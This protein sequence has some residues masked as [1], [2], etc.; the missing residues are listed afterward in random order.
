MHLAK[1]FPESDTPKS[2]V[3][4]SKLDSNSML[5]FEISQDEKPTPKPTVDSDKLV[6]GKTKDILMMKKMFEKSEERPT[7]PAVYNWR[8]Y[9]TAMM[10]SAAAIIIGYDG[11]FIGGTVALDSFLAEFGL[12]KMST[13]HADSIVSDIISVFHAGC[14]FGA[15][16]SYPF[17]YYLG[18]RISLIVAAATITIGSAIMLAASSK[19]GLAPLYVGRV[20]A[21]LAVGFSTNL[22]PVYLSEIS[23]PA[24]RGRVIALYEIGWRIGDLVGFWINYG[25]DSHIASS[26]KQW[27]IPFAIQLIPS[28]LFLAGSVI[29]KESPRW[30]FSVNRH[31]Q[32]I[33]NLTW[34]RN[35]NE[36]DEYIVYEVNQVKE[37]IE[38][39][40]NNVGD[41]LFDPFK[42]VF[43]SKDRKILYRLCLT[44]CLFLF[45]NFLGIQSINYYSPK[46]FKSLGVKG[47][48][49][50]LFSTGIFGIVKFVCTFIYILFIV[51]TFGR[52]KAFMCSS[53]I[54][55]I[56]FWYIGSYLKIN[57]P[58][59]PGVE[60]G[61][62]GTAA[63]VMM[64][65]WIASFILAWSG[66]PFVVGSEVFDQNIRSFVQAIN[67]AVS[68]VPIFI[69]S[70]FTTN[71]IDKM[72]YGIYYFFAALAVLSVPF[73]FF[74]IPETKGVALE[75]M[76]R[77]FD[78]NLPPRLAN[79]IVMKEARRGA[80]EVMKEHN[81]L[82]K[83]DTAKR[84]ESHHLEDSQLM[85]YNSEKV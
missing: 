53:T 26:K 15:L 82:F 77:L 27:F 33:N 75:D 30:L 45:Q 24:I 7:P 50:T 58:T 1:Q 8:I 11:G 83:I 2:Y 28:G 52:R 65:I 74:C 59:Q 84:T 21:G 72:G 17:S 44:C 54:C 29:M 69:M 55:S 16:I 51:D 35:L 25:I 79:A 57:D 6:W 78:K 71:M 73:V 41:G 70:R 62:G 12:D 19:N 76:D 60:A 23:P 4:Y 20:L 38:Y 3:E 14:F 31:D 80:E 47:T 42:E 66:G 37:S 18:R 36:D 49:A 43:L 22:T 85:K 13:S 40:K 61:P 48:N 34:F 67:A 81:G 10:A 39:Q 64:Y 68:W 5:S 46:I 32:A 63:I 9:G 56:C